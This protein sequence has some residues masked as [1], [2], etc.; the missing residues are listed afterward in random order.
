MEKRNFPRSENVLVATVVVNSTI[1]NAKDHL[2]HV[3]HLATDKLNFGTM[4]M[5]F[6]LNPPGKEPYMWQTCIL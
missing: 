2:K 3:F 4:N 1:M 6:L 5:W